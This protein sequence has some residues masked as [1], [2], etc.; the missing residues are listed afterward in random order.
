L[1]QISTKQGADRCEICDVFALADRVVFSTPSL[2]ML[3][4]M[5]EFLYVTTDAEFVRL[6]S[7]GEPQPPRGH[8]S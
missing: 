8:A 2:L 7:A 6:K 3:P 5:V 1:R 4:E